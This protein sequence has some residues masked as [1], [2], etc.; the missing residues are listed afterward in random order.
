MVITG[1]SS[2]EPLESIAIYPE[3]VKMK[4]NDKK[5]LKTVLTPSDADDTTLIWSSSD[6]SVAKV[7]DAGKVTAVGSGTC[8]ITA[9]SSK[10][11]NI[12]TDVSIMVRSRIK[13]RFL[14]LQRIAPTWI[15]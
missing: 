1:C 8:T 15:C 6:E 10:Y 12:S 9:A 2:S 13:A 5:K 7:D 11:T 14:S 4:P 3:T